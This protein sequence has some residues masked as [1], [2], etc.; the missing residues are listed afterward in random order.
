MSTYNIK[1]THIEMAFWQNSHNYVNFA[2]TTTSHKLCHALAFSVLLLLCHLTT[3]FPDKYVLKKTTKHQPRMF[4]NSHTVCTPNETNV[5]RKKKMKANLAKFILFVILRVKLTV[6]SLP[7]P[8]K[9][10]TIIL[11]YPNEINGKVNI[12][13]VN[14]HDNALRNKTN[15]DK[16]PHSKIFQTKLEFTSN[17]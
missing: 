5:E 17:E 15:L 8:G 3:T 9:V 11:N 10:V 1:K 14:F 12:I 6:F 4:C 7:L 2:Q 16:F 13:S